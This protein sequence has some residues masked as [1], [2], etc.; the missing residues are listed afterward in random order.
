MLTYSYSVLPYLPQAVGCAISALQRDETMGKM[1][2][3]HNN[4][5]SVLPSMQGSPELYVHCTAVSD[6]TAAASCMELTSTVHYNM[7]CVLTFNM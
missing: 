7:V 1:C 2:F 4:L 3:V 6:K 5:T